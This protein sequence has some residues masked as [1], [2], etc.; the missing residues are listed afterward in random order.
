M[1][2]TYEYEYE[3]RGSVCTLTVD[4]R[5]RGASLN[6]AEI[7]G[8]PPIWRFPRGVR[9]RGSLSPVSPRSSC[10][11]IHGFSGEARC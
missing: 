3:C 2:K 8:D 11:I 1:G 4:L 5:C 9:S 7:V 10:P 6:K